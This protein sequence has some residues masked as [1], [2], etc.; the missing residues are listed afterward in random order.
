VDT[1]FGIHRGVSA[2]LRDYHEPSL[3]YE[4]S[5][6]NLISEVFSEND[7]SLLEETNMRDFKRAG[8]IAAGIVFK[9]QTSPGSGPGDSV[10]L[11]AE[12]SNGQMPNL[13]LINV[14]NNLAVYREG[15]HMNLDILEKMIEWKWLRVVGG[16]LETLGQIAAMINAGWKFS[17]PASEFVQG[18]ATLCRSLTLQV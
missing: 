3:A 7:V 16:S 4:E 18:A 1:E 13:D 12:G 10:K 17:P 11:Y 14:V 6:Y 5:S 8:V 2:W 9:F 15:L